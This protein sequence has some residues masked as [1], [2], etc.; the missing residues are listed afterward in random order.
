M[1]IKKLFEVLLSGEDFSDHARDSLEFGH[2]ENKR[3]PLHAEGCDFCEAWRQALWILGPDCPNFI[4][5]EQGDDV[6]ICGRTP[7]KVEGIRT[8]IDVRLSDSCHVGAFAVEF[9]EHAPASEFTY[10]AE[11]EGEGDVWEREERTQAMRVVRMA[12]VMLAKP[13]PW[14]SKPGVLPSFSHVE[15]QWGELTQ[16]AKP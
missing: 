14:D 11:R 13:H 8:Q 9:V 6:L 16:V 15:K 3:T 4:D 2:P 7:G 1:K 10:W 12:G 5:F